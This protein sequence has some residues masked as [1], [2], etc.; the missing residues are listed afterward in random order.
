MSFLITAAL[1]IPPVH[2]LPSMDL[3]VAA[4][5]R[6]VLEP[7][8]PLAQGPK[9]LF[10]TPTE[11]MVVAV[12]EGGASWT[13]MDMIEDYGRLTGQHMQVDGE[14]RQFLE[15]KLTGL[16]RSVVVPAAGVQ[17]F[18]EGLLFENDFV[19]H[20]VR[21]SEPRLLRISSLQTSQRNMVRSRAHFVPE[22]QLQLWADHPALLITTVVH[23]PNTDVRQLSNSMRTMITDSNTQQMLPAG[24][25]NSMVLTG[26]GGTV[27]SLAEMLRIVDAASAKQVNQPVFRRFALEHAV[28]MDVA[29]SI[30]ELANAAYRSAGAKQ[31]AQSGLPTTVSGARVIADPR[32]NALVVTCSAVD[33]PRVEEL[34]R[35]FDVNKN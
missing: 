7:L 11:D 15:N 10:P 4:L 13:M 30:E 14:T 33:L 28:A 21:A 19:L 16:T 31:P 18:F 34:V 8:E 3:E 12:G 2:Q 6:N 27:A 5:E 17:G 26:F 24:N 9:D 25:T 32:T 22:G 23:L 29:A 35:L 20:I 1:L